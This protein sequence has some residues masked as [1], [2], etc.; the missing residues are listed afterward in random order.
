[1]RHTCA[2]LLIREGAGVMAVSKQLGH[3]TPTVTLNVYSHLF[4]DDLDRL[5][6]GLDGLDRVPGRS[7]RGPGT[8]KE[9][10]QTDDT[11]AETGSD[12]EEQSVPPA[13]IEPATPGLGNLCSIH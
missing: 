8:T 2:S 5:Y 6:A 4:D 9:E 11:K 1:L 12:L 3:S 10:E 7:R 13:G